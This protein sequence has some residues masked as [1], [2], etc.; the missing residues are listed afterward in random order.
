MTGTDGVYP[1]FDNE[2]DDFFNF[3]GSKT[4]KSRT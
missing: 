1:D 4:S 3:E 2:A